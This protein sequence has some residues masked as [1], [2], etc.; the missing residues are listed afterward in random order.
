[1]ICKLQSN[2]QLAERKHTA[3]YWSINT[4]ATAVPLSA[5]SSPL[6]ITTKLAA[7]I[8]RVP[9]FGGGG[10]V[11]SQKFVNFRPQTAE[12]RLIFVQISSWPITLLF[13]FIYFG[14]AVIGVMAGHWLPYSRGFVSSGTGMDDHSRALV[15][16]APSWYLVN[17]LGQLSLAIPWWI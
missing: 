6:V 5:H 4:A 15:A 3:R 1:M 2:S 9:L 8:L 16:F 11:H 17:H 14:A 12:I 13:L 10:L 7:T